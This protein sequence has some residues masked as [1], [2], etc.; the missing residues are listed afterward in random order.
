M[1]IAIAGAGAMGC[2]Y[3][4]MLKQAGN[5]VVLLDNWQEHIDT[6][7]AN[8]LKVTEVGTPKVTQIKAYRP[9]EYDQAVDLIV[10][11]TKSLMLDGLMQQIKHLIHEDT[12]VL[13]LLNGLGHVDTIS[14]YVSKEQIFM[15]V[16]VLTAK[17]NAVDV[18]GDVSFSSYGKT[19]IEN[20][21]NS[22]A[23]AQA[24][25][26][27]AQTINDSGLP[28]EVVENIQWAT[29]RKACLNGAMNSLCTIL[30]ANMYQLGTIDNCRNLIQEIV[31]EFALIAKIEGV[32]LDVEQITDFIMSFTNDGYSGSRHYPSMHQDLIKNNRLTE[33][34]FLNGYI[35]RKGKEFNVST[36]FNNLIT[37][38]VHG[39]EKITHAR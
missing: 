9:E 28:C 7:N 32:H 18:P 31:K 19:E 4:H 22:R 25:K 26:Q 1:K 13:C 5:D 8:G 27:I 21:V 34:D 2:C 29:W 35:A 11:F 6:I 17:F 36:P 30:D 24:A 16:T 23:A 12:K 33:I 15:G 10:I 37:L 38:L 39:K 20:I 3:G 14:K